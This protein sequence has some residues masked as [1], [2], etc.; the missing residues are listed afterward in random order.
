MTDHEDAYLETAFRLPRRSDLD[1]TD[2]ECACC[3]E[4]LGVSE[5]VDGDALCDECVER[6]ND[7]ETVSALL[8]V[9]AA[10]GTTRWGAAQ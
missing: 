3:G 8:S 6:L 1:Y 9:A 5:R 7:P 2:P 4:R 10:N